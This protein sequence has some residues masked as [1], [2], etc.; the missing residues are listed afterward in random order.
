M[1]VVFAST[2]SFSIFVQVFLCNT[3]LYTHKLLLIQ[4]IYIMERYLML[5]GE[6]EL[7]GYQVCDWGVLVPPEDCEGCWLSSCSSSVA[8]HWRRTSDVLGLILTNN[9][10]LFHF[11]HPH[12]K[13]TMALTLRLWESM[14]TEWKEKNSHL[15]S[16]HEIWYFINQSCRG[17]SQML[18]VYDIWLYPLQDWWTVSMKCQISCRQDRWEIF[19]FHPVVQISVSQFITQNCTCTKSIM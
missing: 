5:W 12:D 8:E 10:W 7:S 11:P 18:D 1:L 13:C 4:Y 15:S 3:S 17:K 16:G 9:C 2:I 14:Y 6:I 19:I